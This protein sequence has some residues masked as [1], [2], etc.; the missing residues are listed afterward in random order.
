MEITKIELPTQLPDEVA[1]YVLP[2]KDL[3]AKNRK[4]KQQRAQKFSARKKFAHAD[5]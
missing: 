3:A 5:N 4:W 1:P 2:Q